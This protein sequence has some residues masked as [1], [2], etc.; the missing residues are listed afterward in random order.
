MV[1][2]TFFYE[3]DLLIAISLDTKQSTCD[4]RH[5]SPTRASRTSLFFNYSWPYQHATGQTIEPIFMKF[6]MGVCWL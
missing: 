3:I 6:C 5:F 1:R 4:V 2:N